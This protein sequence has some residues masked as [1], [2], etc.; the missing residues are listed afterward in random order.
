MPITPEAASDPRY[1]ARV[2]NEAITVDNQA[3]PA[4][5][6]AI[7]NTSTQVFLTG[8]TVGGTQATIAHGL[9]YTPKIYAIKMKS[10]GTCWESQAPD[11]TNVYVTA[12]SA[13][14][15]VDLIVGY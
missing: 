9:S 3:V 13:G 14:R 15:S 2:L 1:L 11:A 10:A 6:G 4:F 7:T 12:D 5:G 8:N